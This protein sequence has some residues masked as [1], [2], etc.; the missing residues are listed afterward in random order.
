M[1]LS[2]PL[3]LLLLFAA[4]CAPLG[5]IA[6][7]LAPDPTQDARY[8][9]KDRPTAILVE[10]FENP[11]LAANDSELLTRNLYDRITKVEVDKKKI[12]TFIPFQKTLDLHNRRPKDFPT[13]TMSQIGKAVGAEQII[14][15][16][17]EN[18]GVAPLGTGAAMQ[19]KAHAMVKVIDVETGDTLWPNDLAEG[20]PVNAQTNPLAGR[21]A[22]DYNA[23]R[24]ELYDTMGD[25]IAK[26][27]YKYTI[28]NSGEP[29]K[30][31]AD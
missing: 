5:A 12:A 11:D 24:E 10:N 27:F 20:F 14:Y 30:I 3:P 8:K 21:E 13:M 2:K 7:K 26:L 23:V 9:L 16:D 18:G 4:A 19:G 29:D 15:V 28:E 1:K 6:Y 22:S 17:L 25:Q 31:Q